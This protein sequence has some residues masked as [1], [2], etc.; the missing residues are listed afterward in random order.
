MFSTEVI[1]Q[2]D[3][4]CD[5]D[6]SY[7][8]SVLVVDTGME[9]E[10][11]YLLLS[12]SVLEDIKNFRLNPVE[13]RNLA[14]RTTTESVYLSCEHYTPLGVRRSASHQEEL[15][16]EVVETI[17]RDVL[18]A[19]KLGVIWEGDAVG[20]FVTANL[21]EIA[22]RF[23]EREVLES[24]WTLCDRP[25]VQES[26][27]SYALGF[28]ANCGISLP[29]DWL[30]RY[31]SRH[32]DSA[33]PFLVDASYGVL[34]WSTIATLAIDV[35]EGKPPRARRLAAESIVR[36]VPESVDRESIEYERI[37]QL[38]ERGY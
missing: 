13:W 18:E 34:P 15:E 11:P 3:G 38:A 33:L 4:V 16:R 35:L 28:L 8:G 37:V 23:P 27:P 9:P 2:R 20:D 21:S 17:S 6:P 30:T 36:G 32:G 29:S 14:V 25:R 22:R 31:W 26:I 19:C 24:A 12:P 7:R 10:I 1:D 5:A